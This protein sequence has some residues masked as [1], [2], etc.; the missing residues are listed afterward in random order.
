MRALAVLVFFSKV[1]RAL[2][3]ATVG[4]TQAAGKKIFSAWLKKSKKR[5][6]KEKGKK[7]TGR[8]RKSKK[9]N[10]E[11]RQNNGEREGRRKETR[12]KKMKGS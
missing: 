1:R 9:K 4:G 2:F 3:S 11:G 12:R 5:R 6:K 10:E 8:E 7:K